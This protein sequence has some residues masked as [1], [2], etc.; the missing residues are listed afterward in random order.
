MMKKMPGIVGLMLWT[1]MLQSAF[2]DAYV[3]QFVGQLD[4]DEYRLTLERGAG[5]HYE[6]ELHVGGTRFALGVR[7][8]GESVMGQIASPEGYIDIMLSLQGS[9]LRLERKDGEVLLFQRV[10]GSGAGG[11]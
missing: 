3:G 9:A 11:M 8:F 5:N 1:M 4:G 6:G 10:T 7:R 2:A